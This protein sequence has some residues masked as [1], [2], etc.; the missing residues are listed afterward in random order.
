MVIQ[1]GHVSIAPVDF[2]SR[3]DPRLPVEVIEWGEIVDRVGAG[4]IGRPQRPTFHLFL[5]MRSDGGRHTV[6]FTEIVASPGRLI[7]IRPGQV[8]V[9]HADVPLDATL[10]LSTPTAVVPTSW[11]PGEPVHCDLDPDE[12]SVAEG[13][14]DALRRQQSRFDGSTASVRLLTTLVDALGA[15]FEQADAATA[16]TDRPAP[17]LAFRQAVERDVTRRHDVTEYA[18]LLGYSARTISRAC[19]RATGQTAKRVLSDRL[20]LE[21]KRL[22]VHTDLPAAVVAGRLG[23]SEPTNFAKFFG[24]ET[25]RS[26]SDFRAEQAAGVRR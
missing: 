15:L 13:L 14:I 5:L 20:V 2:D 4:S 12:L 22:L 7:Q 3:V 1:S 26:P 8:Q 9:W 11:F 10:V 18:D 6:D 16:A 23:F 24:R 17:Y 25:G 21:A 19:Q